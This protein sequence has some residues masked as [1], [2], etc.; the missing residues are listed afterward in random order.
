MQQLQV[1]IKTPEKRYYFGPADSVFLQTGTGEMEVFAGH[2]PLVG[3]IG[4]SRVLVRA[5]ESEHD[6]LVRQGLVFMDPDN[7]T[8]NV[9]AYF[10]EKY[11]D[12]DSKTIKEYMEFI[13]EK[14][15]KR[16]DLNKYQLRY[17]EE[18]KLSTQKMMEV[19][20]YKNRKNS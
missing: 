14:L 15:R 10:V 7:N 1:K 4:F 5:A 8:L 6:F 13:L 19:L 16:E 20:E 3:T 2:A 17:L 9:L 11:A 12:A 18:Q